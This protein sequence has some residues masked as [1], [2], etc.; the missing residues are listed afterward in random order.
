MRRFLEFG[1]RYAQDSDWTDFALT[2]LCVCSLGVLIGA[3]I[4]PGAKAPAKVVAGG[5]FA[6][7]YAVL[8]ARVFQVLVDGASRPR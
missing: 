5:L 6:T 7:T 3:S 4:A 8:M 2:K 1:N